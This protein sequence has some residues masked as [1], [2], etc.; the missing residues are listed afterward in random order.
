MVCKV[1]GCDC[2]EDTASVDGMMNVI[3]NKCK[4]EIEYV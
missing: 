1:C 4:E 2:N 3:C